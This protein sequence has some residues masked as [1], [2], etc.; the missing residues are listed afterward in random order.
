M[1]A[2]RWSAEEIARLAEMRRAG[3]SHRECAAALGR[4]L[5][6]VQSKCARGG[7]SIRTFKWWTKADLVLAT[8]MAR[9]GRSNREI[10]AALGRSKAAVEDKL[11][12]I[13][14]R[15]RAR[16]VAVPLNVGGYWGHLSR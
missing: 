2:R 12:E 14:T 8:R 1:T 16:G 10:G 15:L 7:L 11:S 4:T 5:K 9:E 13:R 3:V 6:Q